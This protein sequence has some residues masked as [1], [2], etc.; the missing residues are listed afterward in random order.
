MHLPNILKYTKCSSQKHR[1]I[2][3]QLYNYDT[4]RQTNVIITAVQLNYLQWLRAKMVAC[5][6]GVKLNIFRS[7][8]KPEVFK[9][10]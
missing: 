3:T 7:V 2:L 4:H 9:V 10:F 1:C 5:C 8:N 6:S